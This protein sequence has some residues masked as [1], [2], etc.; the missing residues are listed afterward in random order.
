M[1]FSLFMLRNQLNCSPLVFAAW[2]F[3][4]QATETGRGFVSSSIFR[5]VCVCGSYTHIHSVFLI[6]NSHLFAT[7]IEKVFQV[8]LQLMLHTCTQ[9]HTCVQSG[10]KAK[11]RIKITLIGTIS[12]ERQRWKKESSSSSRKESFPLFLS[13]SLQIIVKP[14]A[15]IYFN[16][17]VKG[18]FIA[19]NLKQQQ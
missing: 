19:S 9:T 17:C 2:L 10:L 3:E 14:K 18:I 7:E 4:V 15:L 1:S 6:S 12:H 13:L 5:S 8:D 16:S 11:W